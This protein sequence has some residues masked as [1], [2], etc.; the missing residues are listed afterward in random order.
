MTIEIYMF[1]EISK[2][3]P[4]PPRSVTLA[5]SPST[6]TFLAS[7]G[8]NKFSHGLAPGPNPVL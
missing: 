8:Y 7:L 6:N 5:H 2:S 4:C 1:V 3:T